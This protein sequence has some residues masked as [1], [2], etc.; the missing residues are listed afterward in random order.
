MNYDT[1]QNKHARKKE[2]SNITITYIP[3]KNT[4]DGLFK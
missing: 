4:L 2:K 3:S 1:K